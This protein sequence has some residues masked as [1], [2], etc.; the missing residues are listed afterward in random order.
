MIRNWSGLC[1]QGQQQSPVDLPPTPL[2]INHLDIQERI[3]Q[4]NPDNVSVHFHLGSEH[5]IAG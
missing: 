3:L 2:Q 5:T 1:T 4:L